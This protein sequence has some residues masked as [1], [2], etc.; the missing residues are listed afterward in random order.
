MSACPA[1]LPRS[2]ER[3]PST[4]LLHGLRPPAAWLVRRKWPVRVHDADHVPATGGVILA[5]NHVGVIDGPLLAVFAPRPVHALTKQE[6][7]V[8][9]LGGFLR[10]AGQIPLC[11]YAADP[12]AI[13]ACLRVVRDGGVA[14]IFP[15]GTRG[16]GE[17]GRFHHGAAYLALVTGAPVVPVTMLG[18]R[19][20]GGGSNALPARGGTIDLVF[21]APWRTA[22][23]PWPRTREHVRATSVLLREHML[24]ELDGALARTRRSLPGPLPA[25]QSE[26][27]P[28]TGLVPPIQKL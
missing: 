1:E 19:P 4:R 13:R 26:D 27:D 22:Q 12:G 9:P 5:A 25:G 24:S 7:F 3:H 6:M 18:T 11:R 8:G 2:S 16:D 10:A 28:D 17:L 20:P 15:E 23:Q 14:G 21:G